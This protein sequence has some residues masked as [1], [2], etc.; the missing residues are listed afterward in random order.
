MDEI[1][2]GNG[3]TSLA[4]QE[5]GT[6][7]ET[8][9]VESS[10]EAPVGGET[11][12]GTAG[13]GFYVGSYKT[14]EEAEKGLKEKDETISRLQSE[15]D[16]AY[17]AL[18]QLSPYFE[19]DENG[20]VIGFRGQTTAST[21][22]SITDDQLPTALLDP[23]QAPKAISYL[24]DR[25]AKKLT[26]RMTY[27]QRVQWAES[28]AYRLFP[29]LHDPN[30]EMFK[31]TQ[32][33]YLIY[34]PEARRAYP[35]LVLTA[36]KAAYANI[37]ARRIQDIAKQAE[38]KGRNLAYQS[39]LEKGGMAGIS[40]Q[41]AGISEEIPISPAE[42][43]VMEGLGISEEAWRARKAARMNKEGGKRV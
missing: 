30:S 4:P 34:S 12:A 26:E 41:G 6:A 25:I 32:K 19:Y 27:A 29:D 24:E 35:E 16:R 21:E 37:L 22:P 9:P 14:R 10:Q 43:K 39:R 33:E 3:T 1:K 42:R 18:Q 20:R 40:G 11:P 5:S 8:R 28:E 38:N 23:E 31:E 2:D 17:Y 36:A 15:R 13:E 7:E